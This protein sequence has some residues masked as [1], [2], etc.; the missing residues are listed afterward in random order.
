MGRTDRRAEALPSLREAEAGSRTPPGGS[1]TPG[2][3]GEQLKTEPEE[4]RGRWEG[5]NTFLFLPVP[6]LGKRNGI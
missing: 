5:A 1:A 4:G 6:G 3:G 2:P